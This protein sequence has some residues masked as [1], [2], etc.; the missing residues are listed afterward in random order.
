VLGGKKKRKPGGR[1]RGKLHA[2]GEGGDERETVYICGLA[3]KIM[4]RGDGRD[5]EPRV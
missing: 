1:Q 4:K 5:G 3:R 2:G